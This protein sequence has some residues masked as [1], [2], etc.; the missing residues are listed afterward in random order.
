MLLCSIDSQRE[1][2][3]NLLCQPFPH[4]CHCILLEPE[5]LD[6]IETYTAFNGVSVSLSEA[7]RLSVCFSGGP[8]AAMQRN[9]RFVISDQLL[10]AALRRG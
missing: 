3:E 9:R 8:Q 2:V 7:Y 5:A 1:T 4:L 6:D 10:L